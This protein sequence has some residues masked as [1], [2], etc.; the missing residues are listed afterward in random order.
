[1]DD[2]RIGI[3]GGGVIGLTCAHELQKT[4]K[5]ITIIADKWTPNTT[6]DGAAA[7]WERRQLPHRKWARATMSYYLKL[8]ETGEAL[9]AGVGLIDGYQFSHQFEED[10]PFKE[11]VVMC[12]RATAEEVNSAATRT[13]EKLVDGVFFTSVIVDSPTY[14]MWLMRKIKAAG[15]RFVH[16]TVDKLESLQ[17]NFDI[18][19]NCSG[20]RARELVGDDKVH[21]YRGQVMRVYAP[22][23]KYFATHSGFPGSEW[24]SCYVLPRPTSG[25]VTLGGTYVRDDENTGIDQADSKRIWEQC[26]RL[27]PELADPQVIKIDEWTGLRPGRDETVRIELDRIASVQGQRRPLLVH[28][29]GHG[30]CG[31]SLHFGTALDVV[32]LINENVPQYLKEKEVSYWTEL[33]TF[34]GPEPDVKEGIHTILPK[35]MKQLPEPFKRNFPLKL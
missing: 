14:L 4:F 10:F 33:A 35:L 18:V 28:A 22:N 32:E 34:E 7:F 3:L 2:L 23:V 31:H 15:G 25:V 8:I 19:V 11:D 26:V 13:G 21:A 1:M 20:L 29:Y 12:R 17:A 24:H 16:A 27:V 6:S 30:G 9:E 5:N